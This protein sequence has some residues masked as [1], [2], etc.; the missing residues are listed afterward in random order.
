M[1]ITFVKT[2]PYKHIN[3]VFYNTLT[4]R[5]LTY[6]FFS[7][8][9]RKLLW[10]S[11]RKADPIATYCAQ[12]CV[13]A[14]QPSSIR[15]F[16]FT[17]NLRSYTEKLIWLFECNCFWYCCVLQHTVRLTR[18]IKVKFILTQRPAV[19]YSFQTAEWGTAEARAYILKTYPRMWK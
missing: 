13:F 4:F 17:F 15:L 19:P 18:P 5:S 7:T 9:R 3:T 1:E 2:L 8:Y 10:S 14:H 11:L 6:H 16:H 12:Q